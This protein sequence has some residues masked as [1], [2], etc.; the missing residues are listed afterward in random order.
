MLMHILLANVYLHSTRWWQMNLYRQVHM[1]E[2]G[3]YHEGG[4]LQ[5]LAQNSGFSTFSTGGG[6]IVKVTSAAPEGRLDPC[7]S[8]GK[9]WGLPPGVLSPGSWLLP[10]EAG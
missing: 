4:F 9:F 10:G 3:D 1:A 6:M 5:C 2:L 8:K 7:N